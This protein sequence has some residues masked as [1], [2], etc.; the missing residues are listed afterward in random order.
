MT[1]TPIR[2]TRWWTALRQWRHHP[3]FRIAEPMW[4]ARERARL[5]ELLGS[6]PSAPQDVPKADAGEHGL[7]EKALADAATNLWR[8][9]KKLARSGAANAKANKQVD[10]YLVASRQAFD[11]A[12][13]VIQDH[14]GIAFNPGLS[15]EALA[16]QEDP[17]LTSEIVLDTVRPSV[18]L[19]D[20]RI[21]MGQVIVGSPSTQDTTTPEDHRA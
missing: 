1:R 14:D 20:R 15:L 5:T 19:A 10:R 2:M 12:G 7:D 6:L 8:A 4:D 16:F 9:R 3:Q 13:V 21:Q 11:S 17:T 18:Y